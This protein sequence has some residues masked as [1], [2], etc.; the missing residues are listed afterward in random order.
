VST[1]DL[2]VTRAAECL[3]ASEQVSQPAERRALLHMA[4]AYLTRAIEI[5][6][7]AARD[8]DVSVLPPENHPTRISN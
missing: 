6:L 8:Q 2:Y 1:R 5:E 7:R 4:S 3:L